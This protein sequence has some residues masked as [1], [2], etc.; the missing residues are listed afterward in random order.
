MT[1]KAARDFYLAALRLADDAVSPR[2]WYRWIEDGLIP[3][4]VLVS[5]RRR[6]R[7]V[8]LDAVIRAGGVR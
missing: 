1:P 4:V 6:V 8:D 3:S 2:Q 7:R 5:G